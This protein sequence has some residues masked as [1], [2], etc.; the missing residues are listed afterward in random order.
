MKQLGN[1]IN[2]SNMV[3]EQI[4][5]MMNMGILRKVDTDYRRRYLPILIINDLE[6]DEYVWMQRANLWE[7]VLMIIY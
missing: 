7:Q 5:D 1:N 2:I 6:R 4:K 3:D